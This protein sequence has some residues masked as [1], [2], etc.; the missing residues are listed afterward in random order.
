MSGRELLDLDIDWAPID[1]HWWGICVQVLTVLY[2]FLGLAIVCDDHMV[3]ALDMLCDRWGI[4]E[5]VAGATFMAFGSAAPEIIINVV[6][7]IQSQMSKSPTGAS[8][9]QTNLGVS[10]IL[11]SGMI[12]FS[13]IPATCA[14]FSRHELN[15]KR[16]PLFRDEFFY[17]CALLWLIYIIHDGIVKFWESAI[18]VSIYVVYLAVV[19]FASSIRRAY[20]VHVLG[21]TVQ[22]RSSFVTGDGAA[23]T[24]MDDAATRL[25]ADGAPFVLSVEGHGQTHEDED[26]DETFI[27]FVIDV[28]AKPL[29]LLFFLTCPN[30]EEGSGTEYLYGLTFFMSFVWVSVF[31]FLLSSV[32]ERWV[33]VSGVSMAVFGLL[34][35]SLGAEIPDTIESVSVA[36]K[37]Y[38]SMAVSNCQGTQVINI[39]IGLGL[40]WL[41]ACT[42]SEI[43]LSKDLLIPALIQLVLVFCNMVILLG[44]ALVTGRSKALLDKKRAVMLYILYASAIGFF[45]FYMWRAGKLFA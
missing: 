2:S 36:K 7:T 41:M 25:L 45:V 17:L 13:M 33:V 12:A 22:T 18:L 4:P 38:G 8:G 35:V 39:A 3:P 40:S 42:S 30:C 20:R 10:A 31:S 44:S 26:E 34:L 19:V 11:G 9:E 32:I 5:D 15:L 16:R 28:L 6:A 21:E 23:D 24:S 43:S 1:G 37:G 14:M 27:G 29:H